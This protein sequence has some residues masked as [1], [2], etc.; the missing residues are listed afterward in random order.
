[1]ESNRGTTTFAKHHK[2]DGPS[3]LWVT[4]ALCQA[5]VSPLLMSSTQEPPSVTGVG[6]DSKS[7]V[8][9]NNPKKMAFSPSAPKNPVT[10][11]FD[12]DYRSKYGF[13]P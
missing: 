7:I 1:M 3:V 12:T 13:L 5:S 9:S 6:D 4:A 10:G 8:D 11:S 2:C